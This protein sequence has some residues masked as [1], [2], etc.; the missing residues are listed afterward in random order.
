MTAPPP[1][2]IAAA[3]APAMMRFFFRLLPLLSITCPSGLPRGEF[4]FCGRGPSA[5]SRVRG[6]CASVTVASN[7]RV[8]TT[9]QGDI[10]SPFARRGSAAGPLV[11]LLHMISSVRPESAISLDV[12]YVDH[13]GAKHIP[14]LDRRL[15][16]II[17]WADAAITHDFLLKGSRLIR[18]ARGHVTIIDRGGLEAEACECYST[19]RAELDRVVHTNRET[20]TQPLPGS[21]AID[22]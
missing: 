14:D 9:S 20:P 22:N 16:D 5:R 6:S 12:A 4:L 10:E 2:A 13:S 3:A 17:D 7:M 1:R 19:I 11:A 18:Y 15:K 21:E 8:T